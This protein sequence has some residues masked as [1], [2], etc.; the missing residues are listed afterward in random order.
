MTNLLDIVDLPEAQARIMLYM[1][2]EQNEAEGVSLEMLR[3]RFGNQEKLEE[4]IDELVQ[5]DWLEVN[6]EG[7][8]ARY[9]VKLRRKTHKSTRVTDLL[10]KIGD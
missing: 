10:A 9:K 8:N 6:S 3:A 7:V 1:M 4:I 5:K 2:R